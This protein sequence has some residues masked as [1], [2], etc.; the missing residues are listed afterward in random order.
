[1]TEQFPPSSASVLS[2]NWPDFLLYYFLLVQILLPGHFGDPAPMATKY[3]FYHNL[4]GLRI[5]LIQKYVK[6]LPSGKTNFFEKKVSEYQKSGVMTNASED[7]HVF[8]VDED[9]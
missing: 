9:F 5:G 6:S 2:W 7:R 1:M 3:M 8:C 4:L